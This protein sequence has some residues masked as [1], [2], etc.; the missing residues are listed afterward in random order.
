MER[1]NEGFILSRKRTGQG[2]SL[3]GFGWGSFGGLIG[4]IIMDMLFMGFLLAFSQPVT[5]CFS[6]VGDTVSQF[7]AMF[8]LQLAGGVTTG[9]A[10]HYVIGP[11]VGILFGIF[12]MRLPALRAG[13]LKK[14]TIAAFVYV[15][16]LSQPILAMTPAFLKMTVS[17]TIQ[18]FGGAFVMH[19]ILA[20]VLALIVWYGFRTTSS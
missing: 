17:E 2:S 20:V 6:I 5:L 12:V 1:V 18:W 15:E 7:L 8:R 3:R 10:A 14:I 11:L 19:L 9:V 13:S 4:T 16:I